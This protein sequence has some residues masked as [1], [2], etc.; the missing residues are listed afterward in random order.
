M[1]V[2][3]RAFGTEFANESMALC[4]RVNVIAGEM[5]LTEDQRMALYT[6]AS[7]L[8]WVTGVVAGQE[9]RIMELEAMVEDLRKQIPK[10]AKER[11]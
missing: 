8:A 1:D 6:A 7:R 11:L 5:E 4:K 10:A 3:K 2:T 9:A